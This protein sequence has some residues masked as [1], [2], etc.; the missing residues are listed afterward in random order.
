MHFPLPSRLPFLI[1]L[2]LCTLL[3]SP[4]HADQAY[5]ES[6]EGER[7]FHLLGGPKREGPEAQWIYCQELVQKGKI[8]KAIRHGR[9]LVDTWPD[10]PKAVAAQRLQADLL[11]SREEYQAAFDAYQ[12]LIDQFAG[13]FDYNAVLSQQLECARQLQTKIYS[14]FFGL[15][16]YEQPLEAIPLYR[17][18]LVNAPHIQDAPEILHTIGNIY[19]S[20]KKYPEAIEEF[21]RLEQQFPESPF[22]EL[23]AL[24]RADA[25]RDLA[26]STPT[27]MR[28]LES[29]YVSLDHFLQIYP[30]SDRV[31]DVRHRKKTVYDALAA[32]RFDKARFYE[33][34]L[35]KPEAALTLYQ[36]LLEQY[37][38]SE[39]TGKAEERIVFLKQILPGG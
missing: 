26:E 16:R 11:F 7:R 4:L 19:L 37:P 22:S 35:Q 31:P 17:Q 25:Y 39:W 5:S 20:R 8:R 38:D 36:S 29:E 18:V 9:Y 33:E 32:A 13:L 15:S 12:A 34:S 3:T 6:F 28:P 30:D 2:W 23:A 21:N 10:H 27:D 14:A 24:R 1:G